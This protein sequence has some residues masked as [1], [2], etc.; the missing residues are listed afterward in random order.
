MKTLLQI[1]LLLVAMFL[2]SIPISAYDF[3]VDGIYYNILDETAKTVE[4]TYRTAHLFGEINTYAG[5]INIPETT[6]N[7]NS[8]ITYTVVGIGGRAFECCGSLTKITIPATITRIND[9][10]FNG[11]FNLKE[12]H[13]CDIGKWLK[14]DFGESSS[15]PLC[16]DGGLY[17]NSK[18]VTNL[19]I[20]SDIDIIKKY[21]F[22]NYEYL[23]SITGGDNVVAIEQNAFYGCWKITEL[24]IPKSTVSIGELAFYWNSSVETITIPESIKHIGL[25]SFYACKSLSTLYFN[26]TDWNTV[27]SGPNAP[28]GEDTPIRIVYIGE[29]VNSVPN[30]L[31]DRCN[32]IAA[33]Y[34]SNSIPP[35]CGASTF[36]TTV[37]ENAILY[38]PD[39]SIDEYQ[40]ANV[41]KEFKNI[42]QISASGLKSIKIQ[43]LE[44]VARYDIHG[45]LLPEPTKGINIVKYSDGTTRKE[46]V[47]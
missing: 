28:F 22:Y 35:I 23:E 29:K 18:L 39:G 7:Q 37:K 38:V 46:I 26:A 36:I 43:N 15:N 42:T 12:I 14:I 5:E 19:H 44:E 47:K 27:A 32:K 2:T 1:P 34:M 24:N 16:Y 25:S 41:W 21:A 31:F 4:V 30:Y 40:K 8:N 9:Y 3:E 17:L 45:R 33:I 6:K 10:A 13:I 11:C 20:P